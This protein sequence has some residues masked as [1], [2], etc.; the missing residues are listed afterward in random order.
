MHSVQA[1]S[2]A[3]FILLATGHSADLGE[4]AELGMAEENEDKV[5]WVLDR[6]SLTEELFGV[7]NINLGFRTASQRNKGLSGSEELL[8]R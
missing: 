8:A 5:A 7:F 4:E 1:S 3:Y 2:L 6:M